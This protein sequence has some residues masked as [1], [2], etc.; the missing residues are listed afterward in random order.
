LLGIGT[1]VSAAAPGSAPSFASQRSYGTGKRP[2]SVAIGDPD[3]DRKP[4]VAT[5]NRD[6]STASVLLN[7]GGGSLRSKRDYS[8]G[9]DSEGG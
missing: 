5:A 9:R 2:V 8:T 1:S 3:G 4:N 6:A 7:R